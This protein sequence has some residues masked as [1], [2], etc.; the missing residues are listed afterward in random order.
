MGEKY[1]NYNVLPCHY[2]LSS[3]EQI[4]IRS[5]RLFGFPVFPDMP[6]TYDFEGLAWVF[7]ILFDIAIF[8]SDSGA[9]FGSTTGIPD[10]VNV[11]DETD[12]DDELGQ[13]ESEF[14]ISFPPDFNMFLAA[15]EKPGFPHYSSGFNIVKL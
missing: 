13:Q 1:R 6:N 5:I 2:D 4:N 7:R 10:L 9:R 15:R 8:Y 3:L 12:A 11:D 14:G